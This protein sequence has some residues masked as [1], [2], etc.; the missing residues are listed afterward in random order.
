VALGIF[1]DTEGS[2][3]IVM[4]CELSAPADAEQRLAIARELRTQVARHMAIALG[5]VHL[6]PRG[7]VLKTS[8]G[9]TSRPQN[10]RKYLE[11]RAGEPHP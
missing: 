9:K 7:W 6:V 1:D 4:V 5:E 8:S 11:E 2:D 3:R 10:R